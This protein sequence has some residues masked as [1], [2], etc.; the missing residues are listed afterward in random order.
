MLNRFNLDH[1][2]FTEPYQQLIKDFMREHSMKVEV[3]NGIK[4]RVIEGTE[5]RVRRYFS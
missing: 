4:D 3:Y 2:T 5:V 1:Q